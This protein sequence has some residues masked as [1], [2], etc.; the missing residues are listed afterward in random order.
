METSPPQHGMRSGKILFA[1]QLRAVA[2]L[3]V[4]IVHLLGVYWAARDVVARHI[5]AP[6]LQGPSAKS[7][8]AI[9][10]AWFNFG[11]FGVSLFFLISGFVIPFSVMQSTRPRFLLARAL[12]IYPTYVV[13]LACG[14]AAI[15]LSGRYWGQAFP[16]GWQQV[17]ANAT[18]LQSIAA[19]ES[20]DMV[21]WSLSIEIK[22]YLFVCLAAAWIRNG[23]AVALMAAAVALMAAILVQR[24]LLPES[25][26]QLNVFGFPVHL[27]FVAHDLLFLPYMLVGTMFAF[28]YRGKM[29]TGMLAA[30]VALLL[31][32]FAGTWTHTVLKEQFPAV[33]VN[34][35]YAVAVFGAAYA[36]R[37]R[38][39]NIAPLDWLASVSYPLYA[40]HSVIGYA[41]I[42]FL[43][44][45]GVGYYLAV[46]IALTLILV[47][48]YLIHRAVE[49]PTQALG[50]RLARNARPAGSAAKPAMAVTSD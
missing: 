17:V 30:S 2:A 21:N 7:L 8:D 42:R 19:V 6:V 45:N 15:W 47:V 28:H 43:T 14:L 36:M 26:Q 22:F 24:H 50:K 41:T 46:G 1:D 12:R 39:R 5:A 25:W 9:S 3:S 31:A 20:I 29:G 49:L 48:A 18:L 23:R 11:P 37:D 10:Y 4:V 34:Y 38:F 16:W 44:A 13:C 32:A 27:V 40:L 35:L 33:P